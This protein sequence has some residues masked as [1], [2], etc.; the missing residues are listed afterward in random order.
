M[1][2]FTI[3]KSVHSLGANMVYT[4][5]NPFENVDQIIRFDDEVVGLSNVS[6]IKREFSVSYGE[7]EWSVFYPLTD[8][9]LMSRIDVSKPFTIKFKYTVTEK[10]DNNPITWKNL[11]LDIKYKDVEVVVCKPENSLEIVDQVSND[12][13]QLAMPIVGL[14]NSMNKYINKNMG[15]E[16]LYFHTKPKEETRDHILHEDSVHEV[17]NEGGT[18]FKIII[19]ENK[20][21]DESTHE[22]DEWGIQFEKTNINIDKQL[23]EECFG[24]GEEPRDEDFMLIKFINR[25]YRIHSHYLERGI[26]GAPSYWVCSLVKYD[27]NTAILKDEITDGYLDEKISIHEEEF[28]EVI[29]EE[30]EDVT[31]I[32]QNTV[33][34]IADDILREMVNQNMEIVDENIYN[35]GSVLLKYWYDMRKIPTNDIA[36]KYKKSHNLSGTSS[37]GYSCWLNLPESTIPNRI[38]NI[39]DQQRLDFNTIMVTF[40]RDIDLIRLGGRDAVSNGTM[41]YDVHEIVDD[42]RVILKTRDDIPVT[43]LTNYKKSRKV[44]LISTINDINFF[45]DIYDGQRMRIRANNKVWDFNDLNLQQDTWYGIDVNMSNAQ[46]YMGIYIWTF[47]TNMVDSYTTSLS[48]YYKREIPL[49]NSGSGCVVIPEKSIPFIY[50]SEAFM[51]NIRIYKKAI[52]EDQ[53]SYAIGTQTLR[54]ASLAYVIDDADVIFNFGVVG[55]G[56]TYITEREQSKEQNS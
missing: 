26:Q 37:W 15:V 48:P 16:V 39:T 33:K 24:K 10:Y 27:D 23:F 40:D 45:I 5:S 46:N 20:L 52:P 1:E 29:M 30:M 6:R 4:I 34:T 25:M 17:V 18:W 36:V 35:N 43:E 19:P 14:Q 55:R 31:A 22:Y 56:N 42:T 28:A 13:N 38:L 11:S 47:R 44:N 32:Q 53:Q 12:F 41:I 8:V 51:S 9:D 7:D 50:G 21:P 54:N 2:L 3:N 49:P